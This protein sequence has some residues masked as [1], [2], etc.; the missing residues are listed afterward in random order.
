MSTLPFFASCARGLEPLVARE[1]AAF[2]ASEIRETAA[3]VSCVATL[4]QAYRIGYCARLPSRWLLKLV[5]VELTSS[6]QLY[7]VAKGVPWHEHFGSDD[8]FAIHVAGKSSLFRDTRF[9]MLRVKDAIA[10][11]MLPARETGGAA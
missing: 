7:E 8:R 1:L 6:E 10:D 9:A 5:E 2:G 11:A 4:E 3:G